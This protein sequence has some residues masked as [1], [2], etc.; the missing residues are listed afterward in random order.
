[1]SIVQERLSPDELRTADEPLRGELFSIDHLRNH[2]ADLAKRMTRGPANVANRKFFQR[3]QQ[4]AAYLRTAHRTIAQAIRDGEPMTP[5]AEWLLDNFYVV[6]EHLREIHED[7]PP[8]YFRELPKTADGIPR[9][10][11]MAEELVL[12]TDSVIQQEDLHA[13]VTEFQ[14]VTPLS[15]GEIWALP[16]MLRLSLVENLRRLA[17]QMIANL[18]SRRRLKDELLNWQAGDALPTTLN[19]PHPRPEAIAQAFAVLDSAFP[20]DA[21]RAAAFEQLLNEQFPGSAELVRAEHRRQAANHVSIGNVITS[22]R[23]ISALDWTRFFESASLTERILRTDP[24]GVYPLMD[25]ESR[26]R[27]R[28][29]VEDLA[30]HSR[31]SELAIADRVVAKSEAAKDSQ[32]ALPVR[33]HVGYWLVDDGR[34]ELERELDYVPTFRRAFRQ[35]MLRHPDSAYFGLLL[36]IGL[37]GVGVLIGMARATDLSWWATGLLL[38]F[39]VVPLSEVAVSLVNLV[40]THLLPPRVLPKLELPDG[41]PSSCRTFVVVPALLT[42]PKEVASLLDRLELHYVGNPEPELRFALLTDFADADN[43][44]IVA[45]A[46]LVEQAVAGVRRLNDS[47]GTAANK[48]FYLFHRR[49]QWNACEQTWMGWERKRGKLMEFNRLLHG[50][51]NTSYV[52]QEGDLSILSATSEA[53]AVPFVI[54][55]DADTRLPLGAAR[56]LIGTLAHPL[57]RPVYLPDRRCVAHG[58]SIL[59]P[60]VGVHLQDGNRTR[61]T[62]LFAN[63]RGV[64]PYASAASDVY[65]DLFGEGSF[66]GKG[67]YD[68]RAFEETLAEAFGENQ[69]LSHDLIEGCHARV[70]LTSDIEVVDGYPARY[71]A[72]ARR[73]HR[74]V[75]GDW[76]ILPWLFGR[77]PCENGMRPNRLSLLSRWKIFDNLR[78]S[79]VAPSIFILLVASWFLTPGFAALW[80]L[81]AWACL[82][83]PILATAAQGILGLPKP[84]FWLSHLRGMVW[85]LSRA[86]LQSA[87][88]VAC[89]PYKAGLMIDAIARTLYRMHVTRKRLLEW[90]TAAATER[91]LAKSPSSISRQ[92]VF[93][94][95]GVLLIATFLPIPSW[96]AAAPWLLAWGLSPWIAQFIS[97]P[98]Q[99]KKRPLS[100]ADQQWL[101]WVARNTWSYFESYVNPQTN[102]LPPDN[103][104]EYPEPKLAERISPTNEGLFLVSA[105][106]ARDFGFLGLHALLD[107]WEKNLAVWERLPKHRGHFLNWYETSTLRPLMPRYVSTVDSGNLAASLLVLQQAAPELCRSPVFGDHIWDGLRDTV[108]AALRSC[109][110]LQPRG[111]H[112]VSPPLDELTASLQ[113]LHQQLGSPPQDWIQRQ[114]L[115]ESL[116]TFRESLPEKLQRLIDAHKHPTA[117][118]ERK[119]LSL[120]TWIDGLEF[121]FTLLVPWLDT[122]ASIAVRHEPSSKL[123]KTI[124]AAQSLEDFVRLPEVLVDSSG[125]ILPLDALNRGAAAA[126]G[127]R[128]R[129]LA[130]SDRVERMALNMDF[131]FLFN[132][133]RRLFAIGY[134][135]EDGRLDRSHYD[136]LCSEAR[137]SSHLAIAKGDVAYKHWFQLGRQLT[138][139]AGQPGLL[140]WGGTMFEFLMPLLFQRSIPNSLLTQACEA[141][142]ARQAEY[143][144]QR[145]VPWGVS[146]SAFAALAGNS[147]YCYQS[148]GVPGLGLKR[149]LADDLV[150]APYATMLA[151]PVDAQSAVENLRRLAEEQALG[152]HGFYEA[153]DYTPQ[154]VPP[155]R[156]SVPVRCFMAHH[157]AMSLTAIANVLLDDMI[158]KRFHSHPL[159]RATEMLLEEAVP[160]D[161]PA[162]QPHETETA[163]AQ[164]VKAGDIVVSRR[165]RG[166]QTPV[167]HA[168]LLSNGT[169]SVMLTNTGG[170]YSRRGELAVNRWRADPL[171]DDGGQFIFIRERRSGRVWSATYQPTCQPPDAYEVTF[172]IDKAEYRRRDGDI[173]THLE[174]VVSPDNNVEL[175]QLKFTNHG[176]QPCELEI[177]SYVEVCLA[178]PQA[179][180]AHPAFQKLFVETEY[181][182]EETAL[183][184]KRRP[185]ESH[186]APVWAFHVLSCPEVVDDGVQYE[187]SR[188][189]FLGRGREVQSPAALEPGV[190]LSGTTGPVLDAV[191]SLRCNVFVGRQGSVELAFATGVADSRE[192]ALRHCDQFHEQRN[193]HRA[194]ELAWI[195]NQVQL[196]H[197]H[198]SAA[199]AQRCQKLVSSLLFP[200]ALVRGPETALVHNRQGQPGLWRFGISG[201]RPILLVKAAEL[202]HVDFVRQLLLAREYW[203][204]HGF[205]V[206]LVILN[207]H[208]GSYLDAL[209]EQLQRAVRE[210]PRPATEARNAVFLLRASQLPL[211]DLWLLDAAAHVVMDAKRGWLISQPET[212]RPAMKDQNGAAAWPKRS[213]LLRNGKADT[214]PAD[215]SADDAETLQFWNG[216][217]GFTDDGKEYHVRLTA[218]DRTPAPW[219]N[220]I[221]NPK[222][223]CLVT[224]AGGG[225]T[226]AENSRQNKLT[227]WSNDPVSDPASEIL[228]LRDDDSRDVWR[229]MNPPQQAGDTGWV[230]HGQGYSRFLRSRQ[231]IEVETLISVAADG[232]VKFV[233]VTLRNTSD[234][235]RRLSLTYYAEFVLGVSRPETQMHL[236][237]AG[238]ADGS[239]LRVRNDYH[240]TFPEQVVFLKVLGPQP[241]LTGD[242]TEFFGRNGRRELPAALQNV[243][244]SGKTG[245]GI[246][247]GGAVQSRFRLRGGE[248]ITVAFLL[249]RGANEQDCETLLQRYSTLDSVQRG[250]AETESRWDEMLTAVQIETPNRELNLF[251]NRWLP[252]QVLSCRLWGRTAFYQ[253]GGAYGFRDQL[254]DV[255]ALVYARP[256]LTREQLLRAASRQYDSGDVQHWWHP[257]GGEGTRTRFSDDLLWLPF[258]A[259]FYVQV[260]GDESVLDEVVPFLHSHPLAPE[261]QERYELPQI[262]AETAP[263]YE[264]CLRALAHG[265]RRGE[266]GL[267]LIGCGDWN[268]GFSQIGVLGRGESVWVGWFLLVLIDEFLPLMERRGDRP[269]CEH[270]RRFADELRSSLEEHAWDGEWYRRAFFDD[271]T[272]LGSRQNDECQIDSIAQSWAVLAHAD[273]SRTDRALNAVRERLV[274]DDERL[275]ALF[276]PPFDKSNL[277]PG[278]I[279]GYLPGVRE[280]GGQYTHAVAWLIQAL[281]RKGQ[282]DQAMTIL[283]YVNPILHATDAAAVRKYR[284]E[285]YVVAADVYSLPPFAGRGGWTW[286]TGSASWMYRVILEEVLGLELREGRVTFD[287]CVPNDWPGFQVTLRVGG[288]T[289][290]LSVENRS[291]VD[292]QPA[293]GQPMEHIDGSNGSIEL[294]DDGQVHHITVRPGEKSSKTAEISGVLP[295]SR[296]DRKLADP[297]H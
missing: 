23:L 15:I 268:D 205:D 133:Q 280:N 132:A 215:S 173:E 4:N 257:P 42:S 11:Q 33:A 134:N 46:A 8:A 84:E 72:D 44:Q 86:V 138:F 136:M 16:I 159:I 111:A 192:E 168:H 81:I 196:H 30:K 227:T 238:D 137:L 153:I 292:H 126:G 183:L 71:D 179:D 91:R 276:A 12:H 36:A 61:Y 240:A 100:A 143:G 69:I 189:K 127:L 271:G 10:L 243:S 216:F 217:G 222:F 38:L 279:K 281:T 74:W 237:S 202:E 94:P 43:E 149:G 296:R 93:V 18:S 246:D 39:A 40:V 160:V 107:L 55:L 139:T 157:Q 77:V 98:L 285:P 178:T 256:D 144:R 165:L 251:F 229:P 54:T 76:Q 110:Q 282:A 288:S 188:E 232:P 118:V 226:W 48:P 258:V 273:E 204:H 218:S 79:L 135:L 228:Y 66:T 278:Y 26:D 155:G 207:T 96:P 203:Q 195:Y 73:M 59:Q 283:D 210:S 64:D 101:R 191:F 213:P 68:V 67:I 47:Y 272:P 194:F 236:V 169:Y 235:E 152:S 62:Q 164:P 83:W 199:D 14:N 265:T 56:R 245:A 231:Q 20:D 162:F 224:E 45:D 99:A 174:V 87:V 103:L 63:G 121:D 186:I 263:L 269:N 261:D 122:Y 125:S 114:S 24:A 112:I 19:V 27:Y 25:A 198:L 34:H 259:A 95:A 119:V 88:S 145:G 3:F 151:L 57:N 262:S 108:S 264:H 92:M 225:Y 233:R 181:I 250:L 154:R 214:A 49:R 190:R 287:P 274:F 102:W 150:V 1:M 9:I 221:A 197:L 230:H 123:R 249:G 206:D 187:S 184:A 113:S 2:A 172:A 247:P 146:E 106:V 291:V 286:Y 105:L 51:R 90:E 60:R 220:V 223:G 32:S 117:D 89:L 234:V 5:D 270:Y 75:R 85:D 254:Q 35:G 129:C 130:L 7:L 209:Q 41:V 13:F 131:Q 295:E 97:L 208:P 82:G 78:R 200:Q 158:V 142:V 167:P 161:A 297:R 176:W 289:W 140:S 175:R 37:A 293:N 255:M 128:L 253:A 70:G 115:R 242:R 180:A 104:Q 141:A 109:E 260:T 28:H 266:H 284:T 290:N 248:S 148:F 58:Y 50:A 244:L 166:Y 22:M 294:F 171:R 185:R 275:V 170:G 80:S 53:P 29:V 156:R 21:N 163:E 241:S 65:Q 219:S 193:V 124:E 252:Y 182:P 211:E 277:E 201:D 31:F 6:E 52:V 267:P 147:D 177:T 116:R 17:A 212:P 120:Q 239:T